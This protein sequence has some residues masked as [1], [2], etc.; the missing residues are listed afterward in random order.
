MQQ[1]EKVDGLGVTEDKIKIGR[2]RC[3]ALARTSCACAAGCTGGNGT[4]LRALAPATDGAS[5]GTLSSALAQS[6]PPTICGPFQEE[7]MAR[8]GSVPR[9]KFWWRYVEGF[10]FEKEST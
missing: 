3:N 7:I 5:S 1:R 9:F 8:V 4:T 10:R 2:C 6:T